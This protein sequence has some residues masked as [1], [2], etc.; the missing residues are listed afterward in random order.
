LHR[1]GL[2]PF[3][4]SDEAVEALPVRILAVPEYYAVDYLTTQSPG[5]DR[6]LLLAEKSSPLPILQFS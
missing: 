2:H 5:Q 1:D 4:A 6:R 3:A